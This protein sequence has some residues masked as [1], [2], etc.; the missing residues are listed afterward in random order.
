MSQTLELQLTCPSCQTEF[1]TTAHTLVD[2]ADEAD[3]EVF[4]QLQ[5]G[6]LNV[7][8]CPKC[9]AN[10][11]VPVPVLLHDPEQERLLAY[12]ANAQEMDVEALGGAI[13]SILQAFI[14]SVPEEK[15]GEYLFHPIVT[16]DLSA[17]QAVARG[18]PMG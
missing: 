10:G 5:N 11:L 13:G 3:A 9:E 1:E 15:R 2:K 6:T 8:K 14:K 12:I 18:E 4:W 7:A 16:D 17:M